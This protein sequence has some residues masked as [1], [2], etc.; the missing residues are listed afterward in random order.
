M[1]CSAKLH[2]RGVDTARKKK[3]WFVLVNTMSFSQL[4]FLI[5]YFFFLCF[6]AE[7][8]SHFESPLMMLMLVLSRVG[9]K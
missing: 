5:F 7:L 4:G 6:I 3:Y 8:F 1:K 2:S 9:G